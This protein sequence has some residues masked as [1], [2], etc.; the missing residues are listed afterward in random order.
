MVDKINEREVRV[1]CGAG[2]II[3]FNIPEQL[4]LNDFN[5]F[6]K[7]IESIVKLIEDKRPNLKKKKYNKKKTIEQKKDDVLEF[8]QAKKEG[9]LE[10]LAKR[11][12]TNIQD[13]KQRMYNVKYQLRKKGVKIDSYIRK[14]IR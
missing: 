6:A 13:F 5:K 14:Y 3:S 12:K 11:N 10:E 1:N 9:Q 4:D 7:K 2:W 8:E